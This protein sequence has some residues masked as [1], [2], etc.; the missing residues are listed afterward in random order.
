[1]TF[2]RNMFLVKPLGNVY[3]IEFQKRGLPHAHILVIVDYSK[4][5]DH[6]DYDKIVCAEFLILISIRAEIASDCEALYVTWSMWYCKVGCSLYA[7]WFLF[8][9]I[10]KE[11]LQRYYNH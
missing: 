2:L 6:F 5:R 9:T 4:P 7:Q 3:P 10:P 1:M 8:K 11:I